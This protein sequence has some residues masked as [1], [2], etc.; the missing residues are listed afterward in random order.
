VVRAI[1]A[2]ALAAGMVLAEDV[3][4]RNGALLVARGYEVTSHFIER[5]NNFPPGVFAGEFRVIVP[6]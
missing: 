2:S 1:H 4:L 5:I 3:R 6:C